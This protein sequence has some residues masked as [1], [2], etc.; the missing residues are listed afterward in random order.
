M[1]QQNVGSFMKKP[2]KAQLKTA[3]R[4]SMKTKIK[5]GLKIMG[6]LLWF[7]VSMIG[8]TL[9]P[10]H[11]L[12]QKVVQVNHLHFWT[13]TFGNKKDPAILLI[14]GNAG[15]AIFWPQTFCEQLASMGYF[16]IRYDNR[17]V[18]L[19]SAVDFNNSPYNLLDMAKDAIAI[20]DAYDLKKVNIV[21]ASMGGEI[22]MIFTAHFPERVNTLT[23][24]MTTTDMKVSFD[25]LRG[26][27]ISKDALSKPKPEILAWYKK[28]LLNPVTSAEDKIKQ[29]IEM[30]RLTNGSKLPLDEAFLQ[31][32]ALQAVAR[33]HLNQN[34]ANHSMAIQASYDL[35]K[36][37]ASKIKKTPTLILH[38]DCDPIFPLDHAHAIK[39]AIPDAKLS[40]IPGM[41]HAL[42]KAVYN[43]LIQDIDTLIKTNRSS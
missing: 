23:L 5:A 12:E 11:A 2:M 7:M 22:A 39:K 15:Q 42:N 3:M 38:G 29:S 37:A 31:Q 1:K 33:T 25:A 9:R 32:L 36:S 30:F 4:I 6:L 20:C 21:G 24:M 28:M 26:L 35:H 41:G 27:P 10:C 8:P 14:M 17:D 34:P 13:E 16:V 19:S 43:V 40:I 18:G